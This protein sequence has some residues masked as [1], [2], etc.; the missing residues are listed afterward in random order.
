MPG[1]KINE[2]GLIGK[3]KE[4]AEGAENVR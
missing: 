2:G 3:I 4:R 1:S